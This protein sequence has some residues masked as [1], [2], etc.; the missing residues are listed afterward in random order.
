MK[1]EKRFAAGFIGCGNMGGALAAVAAKAAIAAKAAGKDRIAV[2]DP[3]AA[4]TAAHAE[5][6]GSVPVGL[7]ELAADSEYVFLGVKPQVMPDVLAELKGVLPAEDAP[8]IV[9][10]AAGIGIASVAKGLGRDGLRIIRIMPNMPCRIGE[11]MVLYSCGEGVSEEEKAGFLR[12]LD[13]AG[14]FAELPERQ[15]DAGCA[16]SGSG[17][18]YAFIFIEALADAGVECG[19]P[20]ETAQTLAAQTLLGSAASVLEYGN[21]AAQKDAV[22]SPGGTTVAGVHALEDRGFRSAVMAAV[23]AG[24]RRALEMK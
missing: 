20:R 13:G 16:L 9:T 5:A 12:L 18:A 24:Y 2:C 10:M 8:V 11:G 6:Y 14:R 19:L 7:A 3:D 1:N 21:P 15:I 23:A 22:C 17:P 4:K